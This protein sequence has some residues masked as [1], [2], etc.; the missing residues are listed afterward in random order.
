MLNKMLR[1][2]LS[3]QASHFE[4]VNFFERFFSSRLNNDATCH[5]SQRNRAG[6]RKA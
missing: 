6:R 3:E 4:M 1:E 5:L 2:G